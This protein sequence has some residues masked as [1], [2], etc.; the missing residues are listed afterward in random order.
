MKS[1]G[2]S[3]GDGMGRWGG[4]RKRWGAF[5]VGVMIVGG[6]GVSV[7]RSQ[8]GRSAERVA[9][10]KYLVESV[11]A[12]GSCHTPRA[13]AEED[14]TKWLSGHPANAPTPKFSMEMMQQGVFISI[15]P[16][17]TAFAGPWGVSYATNL[18]PDKE[19]G[20]GKWTE[21]RF[22]LAMR[23]GQHLGDPKG[24]PILPP[25]PWKHY[26]SMTDEDLRSIWAYLQ[27]IPPVRNP[28]PQALN[29]LGKPY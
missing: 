4:A 9:R 16:T 21:E 24:R 20:L 12:C 25:M 18:T 17:Y 23:T 27:T 2:L 3:K 5:I 13:G 28:V 29:R 11:G 14:Q 7:A 1:A 22:V 10:G 15:N 8:A 6:I 26:Q 19:T